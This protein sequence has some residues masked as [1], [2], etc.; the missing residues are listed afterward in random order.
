MINVGMS[1]GYGPDNRYSLEDIPVK[2]HL[3]IFQYQLYE[4]YRD[5]ILNKLKD[6]A[7]VLAVHLPLDTM[8]AGSKK[9]FTMMQEIHEE[10]ECEN[11][12]IHP[13]KGIIDF[14][15]EFNESKIPLVLC[16]ETFNWRRHKPLRSPL[17]IIQTIMQYTQGNMAM[18]LDTSHM[19]DVWF[20]HK[21][22]RFLL[23]YTCVI[24]LSN[25]AVGIGEHLPFNHSKGD[26]PLIKFVRE[27]KHQYK[28]EGNIILEYMP[29]YH[30]K[31]IKNAKYIERLLS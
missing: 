18:T 19:E 26:L 10:T 21:I 15:V 13:N 20:D 3:A 8:R 2:V 4:K 30:D 9:I 12:V 22:M 28:W 31:L 27:L 6:S 14:L 24:H 25:R 23:Q 7:Q 16:I 17:D 1:Y 11:F 5:D 29:E